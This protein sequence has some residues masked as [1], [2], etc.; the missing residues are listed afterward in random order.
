M[1]IHL[2]E[3]CSK[4]RLGIRGHGLQ[5]L[6]NRPC[7]IGGGTNEVERRRPSLHGKSALDRRAV[8]T[9][10]SFITRID[11]S[12]R[13]LELRTLCHDGLQANTRHVLVN[14]EESSLP[15]AAIRFR[16]F[17]TDARLPVRVQRPLPGPS[18]VQGR[19]TNQGPA[20]GKQRNITIVASPATLSHGF[21]PNANPLT[22]RSFIWVVI[23]SFR[24]NFPTAAPHDR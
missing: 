14:D 1:S 17:Q 19:L 18:E 5:R 22:K 12:N 3:K 21:L 8:R 4:H 10:P 7:G 16:N 9:N 23:S 2:N 13:E 11:G 6:R 24:A 20:Q 15:P